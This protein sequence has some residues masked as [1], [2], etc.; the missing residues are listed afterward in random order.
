MEGW[1]TEGEGQSKGATKK[2]RE[3]V[4]PK[5]KVPARRVIPLQRKFD[6][7]ITKKFG[8]FTSTNVA[9]LKILSVN[10]AGYDIS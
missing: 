2:G 3:T 8:R 5:Q 4:V 6:F 7:L 10:F 9:V 1:V